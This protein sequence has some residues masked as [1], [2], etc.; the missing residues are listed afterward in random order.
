MDAFG[1]EHEIFID[2]PIDVVWRTLTEPDQIVQWFTDRAELDLRPGG[3]GVLT[4][5]DKA[6]TRPVTSALVVETVEP[7]T[8]FS[9]RWNQPAGETPVDGNSML[10]EFTLEAH[11]PERTHLRV[12]ETGLGT[13]GWSDDDTARYLEEHR[14][15]WS[16]HIASLQALLTDR[17]AGR[18]P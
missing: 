11:G 7:P 16:V 2:A 15:G 8:R 5:E 1:I 13:I 17:S 3:A 14:N 12:V 9:F 18:A 6:T 10:V 4:W